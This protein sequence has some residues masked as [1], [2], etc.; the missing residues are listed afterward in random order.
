M[1][2]NDFR[3][4]IF[5]N[6]QYCTYYIEKDCTIIAGIMRSFGYKYAVKL[7]KEKLAQ[8]N[9]IYR[10]FT[11]LVNCL[12]GVEILLYVY[13]FMFPCFLNLIKMNY[14]VLALSLS[15]IPLV[16]LYITYIAVNYL[17]EN[18][19]NRYVGTFQKVKF[20][21]DI[22]SI[23]PEAY[24]T[25]R[26]TPK[27]SVYVMALIMAI[28]LYFVLMPIGIDTMVAKG[29]YKNALNASNI[30]SKLIP[31]SS[32]VYAQRAYSKFKLGKY[33]DAVADYKLAEAY[34][35]SDVFNLDILG[36]KTYYMPFNAVIDE[37]D[38][39]IAKCEEKPEKQ[40]LMA[41]KANYLMKNKKYNQALA[42]YNELISSYLKHEDIAFAPDEV[43][44][45]RAEA[46]TQLGD[47]RGAKTD[48]AIAKKM[49][50]DCKYSFDTK[51]IRMP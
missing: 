2:M 19:L 11:T 7:P 20:Q 44:F 1:N 43:Y 25:Y 4:K 50:P 15:I 27:K 46:R 23:E 12:V 13:L 16:M 40:F 21:P 47:I 36:V 49:C 39:E 24:E 51:L 32:D 35:L 26:K 45:H 18:Y 37:F 30:Y 5:L 42:I 34:S 48:N 29:K 33:E 3:K 14:F 6:S 31:I 9:A 38:A 17:Y 22:Y 28:F 8:I 41:E 10:K